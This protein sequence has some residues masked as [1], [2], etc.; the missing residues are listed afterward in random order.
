M[1]V[2]Y[3]TTITSINEDTRIKPKSALWVLVNDGNYAVVI[4]NNFKLRPGEKFGIDATIFYSID[5][6][7][8]VENGTEY[9]VRFGDFIPLLYSDVSNQSCKLIETHFQIIQ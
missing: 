6:T 7:A 2:T 1:Q 3:F 9:E 5:K 8:L 4:N